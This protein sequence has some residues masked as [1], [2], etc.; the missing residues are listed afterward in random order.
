MNLFLVKTIEF[1]G[2]QTRV[3]INMDTYLIRTLF[4]IKL[5]TGTC[6]VILIQEGKLNA[7]DKIGKYF[8]DLEQGNK[9]TI[10]QN[11]TI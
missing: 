7:D 11:K 9:V 10:H 6:V 8:P 1:A 4:N 5:F 3:R 2:R